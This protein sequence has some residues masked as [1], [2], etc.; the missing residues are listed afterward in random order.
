MRRYGLFSAAALCLV[1]VV[2]LIIDIS[3]R[4][5][6]LGHL[7]AGPADAPNAP[8]TLVLGAE[9]YADGRPSPALQSR[10]DENQP[11][12]ATRGAPSTSTCAQRGRTQRARRMAAARSQ[13]R[14]EGAP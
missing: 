10:L 9:V 3:V 13:L 2:L 1:L 12:G 7:F 4:A 6:L 5:E 14:G 8:V 11:A